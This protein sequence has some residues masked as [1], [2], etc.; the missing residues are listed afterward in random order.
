MAS[1]SFDLVLMPGME[2]LISA[3]TT[4]GV[5]LCVSISHSCK[6]VR[7]FSVLLLQ[8]MVEACSLFNLLLVKSL[9][10]LCSGWSGIILSFL[11]M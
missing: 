8:D 9:R 5:E 11:R 2:N 4:S 6:D 3:L 7:L 10:R 1:L